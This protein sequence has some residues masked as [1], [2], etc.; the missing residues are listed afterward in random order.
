MFT[1]PK[2]AKITKV[3]NYAAASTTDVDSAR[4]DMAGYDSVTFIAAVGDVTSGSVL[5]LLVKSNAADSTSGSTTELTGTAFTAGAS[6]AD[7]SLL[8]GTVHKPT[9][10]YAY[11]TLK[12]DTQNAVFENIIAVQYNAKSLPVTQGS[13]VIDNGIAGPMA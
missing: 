6:D 5:Q 2:D 3:A 9:L 4:V 13:L 12:I 8:I 11:A 1:I 10:R 7:N